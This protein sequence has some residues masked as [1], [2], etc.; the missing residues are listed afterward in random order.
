MS[1]PQT[2]ITFDSTV[3]FFPLEHSGSGLGF[4]YVEFTIDT[5]ATLKLTLNA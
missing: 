2:S 4:A 5:I 1:D 3:L